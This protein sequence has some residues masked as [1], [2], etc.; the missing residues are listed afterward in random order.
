M[1]TTEFVR[2]CPVCHGRGEFGEH[3]DPPSAEPCWPCNGE[4]EMRD[5]RQFYTALSWLAAQS[6]AAKRSRIIARVIGG[7]IV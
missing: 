1:T 4:G 5:R 7:F 3:T 6:R 2:Q